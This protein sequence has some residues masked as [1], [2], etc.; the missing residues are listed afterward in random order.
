MT[1]VCPIFTY[2]DCSLFQISEGYFFP[3]IK[4]SKKDLEKINVSF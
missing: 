3:D 1:A 2:E 4:E